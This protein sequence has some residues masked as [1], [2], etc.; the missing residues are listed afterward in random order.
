MLRLH[1]IKHMGEIENAWLEPSGD[2]SLFLYD[3]EKIEIKQVK[4]GLGQ[5]T[6]PEEPTQASTGISV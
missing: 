6:F 3:G 2:V 1:G 4:N 5:S